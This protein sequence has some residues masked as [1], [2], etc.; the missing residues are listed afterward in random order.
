MCVY[1]SL[2]DKTNKE[3]VYCMLREVCESGAN[4]HRACTSIDLVN[5]LRMVKSSSRIIATLRLPRL[6]LQ[7]LPCDSISRPSPLTFFLSKYQIASSHSRN[8]SWEEN[9][10]A[11]HSWDVFVFI[12]SCKFIKTRR[13][14]LEWKVKCIHI[15]MVHGDDNMKYESG[16]FSS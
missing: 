8:K 16:D 11:Q 9:M 6:K 2:V 5:T 4:V 3:R 7:R 1:T 14:S 15:D 13:N 12:A 10:C